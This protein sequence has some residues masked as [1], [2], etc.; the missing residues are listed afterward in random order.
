M[1]FFTADHHFSHKN[2]IKYC[3]RPFNS[4]EEMDAVMIERWNAVVNPD[5][6]VYHLGDFTLGDYEIFMNARKKLKGKIKIIPGGHDWR[7]MEDYLGVYSTE[8][9]TPLYSLELNVQ[10]EKKH[11]LVIV[12]CHFSM[13]VWDRSHYGSLHL[14][15]HSHGN[16]AGHGK[17]M[18]VG[19]DTNRFYPYF[20]EEI[21]EKLSHLESIEQPHR[22]KEADEN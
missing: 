9:L 2:V 8:I 18:D 19:V 21:V 22:R 4:V 11:P 14:Y 10:E 13:R 16:L 15:G 1:I 20:L 5:D 3:K 12:L 17:S 7:W 6:T